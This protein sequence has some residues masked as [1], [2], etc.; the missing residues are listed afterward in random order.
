VFLTPIADADKWVEE[1]YTLNPNI[2]SIIT[3]RWYLTPYENA[4]KW[5]EERYT[6]DPNTQSLIS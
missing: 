6:L 1:C 2:A 3:K 4:D 5:G